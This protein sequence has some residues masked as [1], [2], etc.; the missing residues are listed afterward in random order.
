MYGLETARIARKL[1]APRDVKVVFFCQQYLHYSAQKSVEEATLRYPEICSREVYTDAAHLSA[2]LEA[3]R[4]HHGEEVLRIIATDSLL[5]TTGT[6]F[7]MEQLLLLAEENDCLLYPDEAHAG[8]VLGPE[9]RG[10]TALAPSFER[11]QER[12]FPMVTFMKG[13][14]LLGSVVS[15]ANASLKHG[16]EWECDH[17]VFSGTPSPFIARVLSERIQF[18]RGPS[19][20]ERRK[21]LNAVVQYTRSLFAEVGFE[22]LGTHHLCSMSIRPQFSRDIRERLGARGFLTSVFE[23][24]AVPRGSALLRFGLRADLTSV[25]IDSFVRACREVRDEVPSAFVA[26]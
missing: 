12:V 3:S 19:G 15:F 1:G 20:E 17:R 21:L 6:V 25:E 5:S 10:V 22:V 14:C 18:I 7:D 16:F 23:P 24:P 13:M 2:L 26:G 8:G 4:E 9:G 11:V